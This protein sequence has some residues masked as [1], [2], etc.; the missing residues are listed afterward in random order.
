[1]ATEKKIDKKT[2]KGALVGASIAAVSDKWREEEN[3]RDAVAVCRDAGLTPD[4]VD[5]IVGKAVLSRVRDRNMEATPMERSRG[6][7]ATLQKI[8][9]VV[10]SV[11]PMLKTALKEGKKIDPK[12]AQG[13]LAAASMSVFSGERSWKDESNMRDALQTCRKAGL[14]EDQLIK[15][16]GTT[17]VQKVSPPKVEEEK[18][19]LAPYSDRDYG[20][21]GTLGKISSADGGAMSQKSFLLGLAENLAPFTKKQ[22]NVEMLEKRRL[23]GLA[24]AQKAKANPKPSAPKGVVKKTVDS[25]TGGPAVRAQAQAK[26]QAVFPQKTASMNRAFIAGFAAG[27]AEK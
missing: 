6:L 19:E 10:A 14:T 20:L 22:A 1:M 15:V 11:L 17:V 26:A 3:L 24:E 9:A 5:N 23:Q 7:V 27:A 21:A 4:Q 13:A 16:V 2:A 8:S 12:M 18:K 25:P